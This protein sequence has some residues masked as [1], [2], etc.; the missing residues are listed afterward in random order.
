MHILD[1]ELL[2]TLVVVSEA[3]SLSA[4]APRLYRSQ[5]AISEQVRKLE[6]M[7]GVV[8]LE[9]GKTGVRL[10]TA[11]QGLV[12]H[13]HKL[14]ALSDA[15]WREMQGTPLTGDLRLVITDYFRPHALPLMLRRI[16][17]Q[18]PQLRLH[19]CIRKSAWIEDEANAESFDIGVS[20]TILHKENLRRPANPARIKLR[21][22]ALH[23]VADRSW[24]P[25]LAADRLALLVLPDSCALQ[26]FTVH[27]LDTHG[28]AYDIEHTASD[29]G[30][31]HLALAA[32][33]G[34]TCLNVSAIPPTA[35][36]LDADAGLPALPEVEFSLAAPRV[37]EPSLVSHVRE[38]LAEQL[39]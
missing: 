39:G 5:S 4:A 38:M 30:G 6:Q 11:G 1:L 31:L 16:R 18:F 22:E 24:A 28:I 27:M 26:R 9:R 33:L 37:G 21:R 15:A 13:A 19:V 34:V 17:A 20:M 10:T 32:G 7:C 29:I 23:W 36:P 25:P 3:G 2:H 35:A 8:L 14:L 12:G